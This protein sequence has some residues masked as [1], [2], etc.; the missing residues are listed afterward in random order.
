MMESGKF[1]QVGNW[2]DRKGENELDIV[3]INEFDYTGIVA[4]VKRNPMKISM[5]KLE[6][7]LSALPKESFGKYDFSLQALSLEDM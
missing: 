1:T 5:S 7:K 3:A 4:E 2:W 6:E